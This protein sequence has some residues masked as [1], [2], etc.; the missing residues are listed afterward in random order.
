MSIIVEGPDGAG[1]TT[2]ITQLLRDLP[3]LE[4]HPKFVGSDMGGRDSMLRKVWAACNHARPEDLY[5][6][7]PYIS[8]YIYS[9][10]L[11][12]PLAA[13]FGHPSN[14]GARNELLRTSLLV[15]CLPPLGLVEDSVNR[16]GGGQPQEIAWHIRGLYTAYQALI[17]THPYPENLY[18]YDYTNPF[19]V[20]NMTD[21]IRGYLKEHQTA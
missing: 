12:R 4:M 11:G 3:E 10:V 17:V 16:P 1:K 18:V 21:T 6:R 8:E 7:H 9:P 14:R 13:G 2:L 19:S 5:D 15:L 20:E